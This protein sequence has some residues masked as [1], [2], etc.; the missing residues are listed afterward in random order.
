VEVTSVCLS[1]CDVVSAST[2]FA[3]FSSKSVWNFTTN[4]FRAL[5][6]GVQKFPAIFFIYLDRSGC[7]LVYTVSSAIVSFVKIG[8]VKSRSLL[9]WRGSERNSTHTF[10]NYCPIWMKFGILYRIH[11][12]LLSVCEFRENRRSEK[13]CFYYFRGWSF[14]CACT[15]TFWK[16]RTSC[17]CR[18]LKPL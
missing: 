11:I 14:I 6:L 16:W 3:Q 1:L 7:N 15:V 13:P 2:P 4:N 18:Q 9:G 17:P 12:L 8:A 10:H 5:K